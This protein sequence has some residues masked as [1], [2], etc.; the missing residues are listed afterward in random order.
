VQT[1]IG[2]DSA[3]LEQLGGL[4]AFRLQSRE[5]LRESGFQGRDISVYRIP[6]QIGVNLEVSV[7]EDISHSRNLM[8]W[9]LR[10]EHPDL[11]GYGPDCF[12]NNLEI[13]HEPRLQQFI[14][15]ERLFRSWSS[16]RSPR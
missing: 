16:V 13:P 11:I 1:S 4:F 9:N 3:A 2:K 12:T 7:D 15:F 8:P 6:Y 14:P 5:Q 10:R